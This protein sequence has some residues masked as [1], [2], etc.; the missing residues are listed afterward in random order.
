MVIAAQNLSHTQVL[1]PYSGRVVAVNVADGE[2]PNREFH[3]KDKPLIEIVND[4]KMLAKVLVP[5][6]LLSQIHLGQLLTVRVNETGQT[7]SGKLTRIG[8]MIDPVSSTVPIEAE[9]DNANGALIGGMTGM[10]DLQA[11][12]QTPLEEAP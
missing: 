10:A 1:A 2:Y 12:Q 7:V 5:A 3:Y 11:S 4:T 9:I 8:A 6:N